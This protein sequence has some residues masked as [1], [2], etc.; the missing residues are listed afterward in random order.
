MKNYVESIDHP[1]CPN[2]GMDGWEI[3]EIQDPS[4]SEGKIYKRKVECP[5]CRCTYNIEYKVEVEITAIIK[6][7]KRFK[8]GERDE[9]SL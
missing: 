6:N 8:K 5:Y 3:P 2:C 9:K 7:S 4:D 1:L